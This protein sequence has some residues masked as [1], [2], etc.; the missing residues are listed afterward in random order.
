MRKP[1]EIRPPPRRRRW[2]RCTGR[3]AT[4]C[5]R[6]DRAVAAERRLAAPAIAAIVREHEETVRRWLK[7]WLAEGIEGLQ[8]RRC[9]DEA[10]R[11]VPGAATRRGAPAAAQPGAALLA[12]DAT[13][14]G[15]LPGRTDRHPGVLR[16][17]ARGVKAGGVVLSRPAR[18]HRAPPGV[19]KRR[20]ASTSPRGCLLLCRRVQPELAPHAA[21]DVEPEQQVMIPT[22]AQ[23]H[24]RYGRRGELPH[25]RDGGA[26]PPPQ[27]AQGDRP[28]ARGAPGEAPDGHRLRGLGQRQHARGRRG[29]G[30]GRA[31]AGAW[32]G[33]QPLASRC[34]GGTS[35]ARSRIANSSRASRSCSPP[36]PTSSRPQPG[37]MSIIGS[38]AI[39]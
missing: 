22:P 10:H 7:R 37:A 1:L 28:P 39:A 33:L 13:A 20:P 18:R 17:G 12:V 8:D 5:S 35:G 34:C 36:P 3:R 6:A 30:R 15:G 24:R 32:S 38:K 31:A 16:D 2:T 23:P 21:R 25:R 11:R 27:A 9:W 4:R 14:A 26:V 19:S 29:G